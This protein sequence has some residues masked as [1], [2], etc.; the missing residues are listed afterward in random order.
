MGNRKKVQAS[1]IDHDFLI[2]MKLLAGHEL[3]V[4]VKPGGKVK[5]R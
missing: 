4:E 3:F 1:A 5:I 2:G